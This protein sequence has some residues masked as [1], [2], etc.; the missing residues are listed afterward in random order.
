MET[1]E[2]WKDPRGLLQRGRHL[3]TAGRATKTIPIMMITPEATNTPTALPDGGAVGGAGVLGGG[4]V[5]GGAGVPPLPEMR[6][7]VSTRSH[8][9]KGGS[10]NIH[11]NLITVS[12]MC[13]A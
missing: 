1:T 3:D 4:G 6:K 7:W 12:P 13:H 2:K 8:A 5:F 10:L 11:M 9:S